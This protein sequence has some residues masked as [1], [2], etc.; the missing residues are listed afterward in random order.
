[1]KKLLLLLA[2]FAVFYS[3]AQTVLYQD[4]L[5][6][7]G[8]FLMSTTTDNKWVIN[9]NYA[10]GAV[11]FGFINIPSVPSQPA[12]ISSPNGNY[13]HPLAYIAEDDGVLC[14][15]Y[16]LSGAGETMMAAM[17]QTVS[18]VGYED[19]TL[20]FW[21][22]GGSGGLRIL[23]RVNGG[24]WTDSGH[25]ITGNP[26]SWQE[27]SFVIS[28]GNDVAQFSIAFEFL[29]NS[30]FDPAPNHY[31]SIDEISITGTPMSGG[32]ANPALTASLIGSNFVFCPGDD[33]SV[34]YEV[35]DVTLNATNTFTLEL[36][37]A[38]GSFASPT[39]IGSVA[40]TQTTGT[41]VGTLPLGTPAGNNYSIRVTSSD[42]VFV[43]SAA[44]TTIVVGAIPPTPSIT[45]L[46]NGDLESSYN[47]TNIWYQDGFV[48]SGESGSI[49]TPAATGSYTVV[50][51]ND[52]CTSAF[53]DAFIYNHTSLMSFDKV[54]YAVYPNPV[55]NQLSIQGDLGDVREIIL[56]DALGRIIWTKL[57]SVTIDV[58]QMKSGV[59]FVHVIRNNGEKQ[60]IRVIKQG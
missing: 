51:S 50:A 43:G 48:I 12:G 11:F 32:G 33:L 1:M 58:S 41:I 38:S 30:A 15:S 60:V 37:D 49:I 4:D 16:F 25:S 55:R 44:A 28:A 29:E 40:S 46:P 7:N 35:T 21:R 23:Y 9:N 2:V 36:S 19:I 8:T 54:K 10:G 13:L 42:E 26:S 3:D 18:T 59:Y 56:Q 14:S 52:T 20:N 53:S 57:P 17:T 47:G 5:E 31:H 22:T 34:V 45:Q 27:E 6:T 24:S 39:A